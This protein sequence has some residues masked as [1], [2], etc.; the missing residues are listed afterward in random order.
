LPFSLSANDSAVQVNK[1]VKILVHNTGYKKDLHFK[2]VSHLFQQANIELEF[3]P[4]PFARA[5]KNVLATPNSMVFPIYKT[6]EREPFFRWVGP[7]SES[8]KVYLYKLKERSEITADSLETAKSYSV[9]V[10]RGYS[11]QV[12]LEQHGFK[13]DQN[14]S[15]VAFQKQNVDRF[16]KQRVDLIVGYEN[17]EGNFM[18]I[19]DLTEDKVTKVAKLGDMEPLYMAFNL[20]TPDHIIKKLSSEL[21][22]ISW[23]HLYK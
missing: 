23:S 16:L 5:Y 13:I 9:G 4:I 7:I 10:V 15:A 18:P 11:A 21:D 19:Y 8:L 1:E 6:K 2:K 17:S 3:A 14:L 22:V 20:S 12:L